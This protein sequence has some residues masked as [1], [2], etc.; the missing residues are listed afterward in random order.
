MMYNAIS[1][2]ILIINKSENIIDACNSE[3]TQSGF[4]SN[5]YSN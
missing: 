2:I 4:V 5:I 3:P 1:S